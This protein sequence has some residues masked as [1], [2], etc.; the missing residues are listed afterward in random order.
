MLLCGGLEISS[1]PPTMRVQATTHRTGHRLLLASASP[2]LLCWVFRRCTPTL[3]K[4]ANGLF[5]RI[6][7]VSFSSAPD[8]PKACGIC[9]AAANNI[10]AT[11]SATCA[12]V[13]DV[14]LAIIFRLQSER[15][16]ILSVSPL[17]RPERATLNRSRKK[18]CHSCMPSIAAVFPAD[19][20]S[21]MKF[22]ERSRR[23]VWDTKLRS[24]AS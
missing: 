11:Q 10:S 4:S 9:F 19:R 23:P 14:K 13:F 8:R 6:S 1:N 7:R 22:L 3:P 5:R 2:K 15:T 17:M 18:Q 24:I 16:A 20:F 12:L 21:D